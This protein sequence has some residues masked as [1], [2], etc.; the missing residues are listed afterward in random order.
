MDGIIDYYG[1][2]IINLVVLQANIIV[3]AANLSCV[4]L[5]FRCFTFLI[6][7]HNLI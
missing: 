5:K 4:N 3:P 1:R 6:T 2:S 7:S